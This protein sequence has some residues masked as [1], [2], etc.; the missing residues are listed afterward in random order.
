MFTGIVEELGEVVAIE[1][2]T[3]ASRL[4][5]RGPVVTSD[6]AHGDSICVN[7]VCLTVVATAEDTFTADVMQET[8]HRSSLAGAF[9]R[10]GLVDRVVAYLAPTLLGAGVAALSGTGIGTLADGIGL[11]ID[12]VRRVGPDLKVTARPGREG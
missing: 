3:D 11:D 4:T 5:V 7:G 10:A 1:P 12:D 8:L 2:L 9:L 6:A